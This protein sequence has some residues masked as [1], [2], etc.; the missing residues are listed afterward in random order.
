MLRAMRVRP[1]HNP[2]AIPRIYGDFPKPSP[3]PR[4]GFRRFE[5]QFRRFPPPPPPR[6]PERIR[7][8]R[9]DDEQA[10]NAKPLFSDRQFSSAIVSRQTLVIVAIAVGGGAVFYI[11]NLEQVP[12][13]GRRRFNC[14]DDAS[15]ER[16]GE[17]M[18][19]MVMQDAIS[20]GALLPEWDR[21]SRMVQRVM[22]R[23]IPASGLENQQW[24]VHVIESDGKCFSR[25]CSAV[26]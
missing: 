21:R 5:S 18:Y 6:T 26:P 25:D 9:W 1:P 19:K 15:V 22:D 2:R 12:V 17:R 10:R 23:L 20:H 16:E 13:S 7:H 14:Y 8:L 4:L 24:E 3:N 11:S